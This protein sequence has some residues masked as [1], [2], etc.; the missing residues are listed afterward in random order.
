MWAE[1]ISWRLSNCSDAEIGL[2][3]D[4]HR[5]NLLSSA[6]NGCDYARAAATMKHS[7]HHKRLSSGA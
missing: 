7:E 3:C 6:Q 5:A 4:Q 1:T 2:I